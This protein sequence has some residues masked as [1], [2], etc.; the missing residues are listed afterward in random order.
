MEQ[1]EMVAALQT[2]YSV[3]QICETLGFNRSNLYYHPKSD[4]S[5]AGLREEI[6]ALSLRYP[7]YGYRRITALLVSKGYAVG[8]RRVARL[9]KA[10]NLSVAV[11]RACQTT[12]SIE[13]VRPWVNRLEN[14][15]V[16]RCDQVW[17]G[18]ITYVYL[19]GHFI[20]VVCLWMS[21]RAWS[22]LGISV[23]T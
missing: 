6:E 5:E 11:K 22:E 14:L 17:V 21:S 23:S 8:Y 3:R 7:T 2:D 1:R 10:A 20:Y 9:M 15:Q 13:G 16:S 18:D 4:P 19:K 12:N